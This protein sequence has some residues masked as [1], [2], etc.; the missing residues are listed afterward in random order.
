MCRNYEMHDI[1]HSS[2]STIM[3]VTLTKNKQ[4]RRFRC[5]GK[6]LRRRCDKG[7]TLY[8]C[9]IVSYAKFLKNVRLPDERVLGNWF[10][11]GDNQR[12]LIDK[13]PIKK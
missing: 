3:C 5:N 13:L 4:Y 8:D 1:V 10:T 6:L 9:S 12:Q 7:Y 2:K 11:A